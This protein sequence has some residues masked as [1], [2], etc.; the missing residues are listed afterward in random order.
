ML[1]HSTAIEKFATLFYSVL[2]SDTNE[3][4]YSIAGHN[5]PIFMRPD[6]SSKLL[7]IGGTVLGF[8]EKACYE[9]ETIKMVPGD[10]LTIY[11]DG[12]TEA[13]DHDEKYYEEWRLIEAL[14]KYRNLPGCDIIDK[15]IAEVLEFS[16][17]GVQNDDMTLLI[18]KREK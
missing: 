14:K 1:Y 6:G 12:I 17:G 11:S 5:P 3:L 9:Q 7:E 2:N 4:T 8:L 10:M 16:K 13:G 18:I 15:V